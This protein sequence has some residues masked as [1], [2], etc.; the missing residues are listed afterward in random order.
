LIILHGLEMRFPVTHSKFPGDNVPT[1]PAKE[2]P[3]VIYNLYFI[4]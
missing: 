3:C 2:T 1:S 4:D